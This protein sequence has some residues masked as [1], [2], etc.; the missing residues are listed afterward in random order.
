[1]YYDQIILGHIMTKPMYGYEIKKALEDFNR[2]IR[3]NEINNNTLYPLLSKFERNGYI[4]KEVV[5]QE[6]KPNRNVYKITDEGIVF[7]YRSLNELGINTR[8][9]QEDF[10]V[11][12]VFFESLLPATRKRLLDE[13]EKFLLQS[14][15][16]ANEVSKALQS[17]RIKGH[18][19]KLTL[20]G[21]IPFYN[22]MVQEELELID[23]YRR[24]INVPC[25]IPENIRSL[26][27]E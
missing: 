13:R 9:N 5:Y 4:T 24:N 19:Q 22:E 18:N 12:L 25:V 6:G 10:C 8:K 17:S 15:Y 21:L 20:G 16:G 1:M 2:G 11:R 26:L 3:G 23:F 7:F 27:S 14:R